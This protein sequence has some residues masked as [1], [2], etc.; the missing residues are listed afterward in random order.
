MNDNFSFNPKSTLNNQQY[1]PS[2]VKSTQKI[3]SVQQAQESIYS[4]LGYIVR[5]WPPKNVLQEFDLLFIH[6]IDS[7]N[8]DAIKAIYKLALEKNEQEFINLTKRSCYILINNWKTNI[9]HKKAIQELIELFTD[10][11]IEEKSLS[12]TINCLRSWIQ[13][14]INSKDYQELKLFAF[15]KYQEQ[16]HWSNRYSSLSD[17]QSTEVKKPVE[18]R[19]AAQ[20]GSKYNKI[21]SL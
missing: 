11:I 16:Y 4:F 20:N 2:I 5:Q 17:N 14:F 6:H 21:R 18:Q 12:P 1:E 10:P 9:K 7:A 13:N 8:S 3:Q 19:K 15:A